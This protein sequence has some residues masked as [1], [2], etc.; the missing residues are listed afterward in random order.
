MTRNS[1]EP[2]PAFVNDIALYE[3]HVWSL[4]ARAVADRRAPMHTPTVASIGL[5]GQP[6]ARVVV[7]RGLQKEARQLRFHTDVRS[8][9]VAEL[10]RDPRVTVLGYDYGAKLQVRIA[11][12]ARVHIGDETAR[13]A[14]LASQPFSRLC[15]AQSVAPGLTLAAPDAL[16]PALTHDDALACGYE[17][18]AAVVVT[19]DSLECLYLASGGH[20]RARFTLTAAAT[21]NVWLAP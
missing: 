17:N 1:S 2:I 9:K 7:L 12:V 19:I 18:F 11:G 14:W 21:E 4:L 13:A 5:D 20:R 8:S 15:Y 6:Q 3:A 16:P 10:A